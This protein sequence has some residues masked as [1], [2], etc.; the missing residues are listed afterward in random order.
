MSSSYN[1]QTRHP[2]AQADPEHR[3]RRRP[4]TCRSQPVGVSVA[5]KDPD[6]ERQLVH[7][8]IFRGYIQSKRLKIQLNTGFKCNGLC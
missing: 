6:Q 2:S 8:S 4:A 7:V 1:A 3:Y 5:Q